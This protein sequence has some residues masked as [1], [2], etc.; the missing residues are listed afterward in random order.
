[1]HK[2]KQGHDLPNLILALSQ[3]KTIGGCFYI[4]AEPPTKRKDGFNYE[5]HNKHN[6]LQ[7]H[8]SNDRGYQRVYPE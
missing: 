2:I 7:L 4:I 6:R 8:G 5:E 1:M 3:P